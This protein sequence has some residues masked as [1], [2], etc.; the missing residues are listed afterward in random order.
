MKKPRAVGSPQRSRSA[1]SGSNSSRPPGPVARRT[2]PRCAAAR[3]RRRR[4]RGRRAG[5]APRCRGARACISCRLADERDV[6]AEGELLGRRR[7]WRARTAGRSRRARPPTRRCRPRRSRPGSGRARAR[8]SWRWEPGRPFGVNATT[9]PAG[10]SRWR[11][12]AGARV[13]SG[14]VD[15]YEHQGKELFARYGIPTGEGRVATSVDEA[16][17]A[18][19]ELGGKVV[20]KAQV[21][22]GGRGKAGGIDGRRRAGRG[23]R[24]GGAHP[25]PRHQ[26]PRHPPAVDRARDLD[27]PRVLLLDHVRPGRQGAPLHALDDGRHG[28]RGRRGRPPG[29]ARAH[30]PRPRDRL[31]ALLRPPPAVRRRRAGRG[32]PGGRARS[33]SRPTA[34]SPSST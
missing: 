8:R 2:A 9:A 21:L 34:R 29:P 5:R 19:A 3:R 7:R 12:G 31:P 6:D 17:A 20:V 4:P 22:T 28:H 24:G 10:R 33:S 30:P 13:C 18:A 16:R 26:G 25:R 11:S 1:S 27:R 32:A 15:L 14:A 23:G